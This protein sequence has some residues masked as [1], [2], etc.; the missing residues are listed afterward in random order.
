MNKI[1][2]YYNQNRR[3]IFSIIVVITFGFILLKFFNYL[4]ANKNKNLNVNTVIIENQNSGKDNINTNSALEGGRGGITS[5][6]EAI[7]IEQFIQY[8]NQGKIEDAYNM[9]SKECK[10]SMYPQ[11]S[12]FTEGYYKNIFK[13]NMSY[14]IQ[15]WTGSIYKVD[16]KQNIL[17]TGN[18]SG[19]SKQDFIT[20]VHNDEA[21]SK[22]NINNFIER[23][24]LN[25]QTIIDKICIKTLYKDT[26]MNYETYTFEVQNNNE[27]DIYL[28][29][30]EKSSTIY[31]VDQNNVK[32][33]AYTN[34]ITREQIH[35]YPYLKKQ[36]QIKFTNNYITGR[37]FSNIVFENVILEDINRKNMKISINLN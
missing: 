13:E 12:H 32:H 30:L 11:I 37:D 15:R 3:K 28:D 6:K 8:C 18:I 10:E 31:V 14:N 29:D 16:F 33:F 35:I 19:E 5:Q 34:E 4:A 17:H 20:V 21:E 2:R 1:I 24:Q 36:V 22:I 26:Y 27:K 25:N 7:I 9:I 23:T